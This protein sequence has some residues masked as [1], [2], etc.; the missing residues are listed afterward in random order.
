MYVYTVLLPGLCRPVKVLARHRPLLDTALFNSECCREKTGAHRRLKDDVPPAVKAERHL[1]LKS[2]YRTGLQQLLASYVGQQLS[3]LVTGTSKRSEDDLQ[4][5]A[6]PEV[7]LYRSIEKAYPSPPPPPT[8]AGTKKGYPTQWALSP[9]PVIY[10]F[11][12]RV[13]VNSRL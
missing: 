10:N 8:Y 1:A 6:R 11:R 13:C 7:S 2:V 3:V 12:E 9:V 5:T 4:G